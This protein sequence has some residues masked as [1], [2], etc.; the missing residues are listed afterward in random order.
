MRPSSS[1]STHQASSRASFSAWASALGGASSGAGFSGAFPPPFDAEALL[2]IF[3]FCFLEAASRSPPAGCVLEAASLHMRCPEQRRRDEALPWTGRSAWKRPREPGAAWRAS[4]TWA[5]GRR[6]LPSSTSEGL[7][8][9]S[10]QGGHRGA[11]RARGPAARAPPGRGSPPCAAVAAGSRGGPRVRRLFRPPETRLRRR[12]P[13]GA[14]GAA[15]R[16]R[17]DAA[18]TARDERA[19]PGTRDRAPNSPSSEARRAGTETWKAVSEG[20]GT[21]ARYRR[22]A[23]KAAGSRGRRGSAQPGVEGWTLCGHRSSS[24]RAC[25]PKSSKNTWDFKKKKK[26]KGG[27]RGRQRRGAP[28]SRRSRPGRPAAGHRR[29]GSGEG[30][31]HLGTSGGPGHMAAPVGN[32]LERVVSCRLPGLGG[33]RR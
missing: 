19:S 12:V 26:K 25:S 8:E 23:A 28:A 15:A 1:C 6:R 27:G 24:S 29:W 11:P 4:G 18:G 14:S 30:P 5:R 16:G 32:E 21:G 9:R 2:R 7:E 3:F 31:G 22:A 17:L 10:Q 20:S 33:V 13:P